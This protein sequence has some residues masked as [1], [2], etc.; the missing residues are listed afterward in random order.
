MRLQRSSTNYVMFHLFI[1]NQQHDKDPEAGV[2]KVFEALDKDN[3]GQV[4]AEDLKRGVAH[5]GKT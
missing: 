4:S 1:T 2:T 3:D 5:F